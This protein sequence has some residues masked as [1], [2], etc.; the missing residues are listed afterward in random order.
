MWNFPRAS[1]LTRLKSLGG[2]LTCFVVACCVAVDI[3]GAIGA[4]GLICAGGARK[5]E[6]LWNCGSE[7]T[8]DCWNMSRFLSARGSTLELVLGLQTGSMIAYLPLYGLS[9]AADFPVGFACVFAAC[10]T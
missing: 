7:C 3:M 2:A 10:W 1:E 5:A 6:E 4:T 8:E 9:F